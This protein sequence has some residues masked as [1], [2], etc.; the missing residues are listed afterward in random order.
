MRNRNGVASIA[1][2]CSDGARLVMSCRRVSATTRRASEIYVVCD[3]DRIRLGR[4]PCDGGGA[5]RAWV[6]VGVTY[7]RDEQGAKETADV[8][9]SDRAAAVKMARSGYQDARTGGLGPYAARVVLLP[10]VE[11]F[12]PR[13]ACFESEHRA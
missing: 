1:I 10:T 5:G 6:D 9:S 7:N 8:M 11:A 4:R 12:I 3:C 2:V 13:P